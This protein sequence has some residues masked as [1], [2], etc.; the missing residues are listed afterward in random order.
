MEAYRQGDVLLVPIEGRQFTGLARRD[1]RVVRREKD[2]L[3]L[4]HGE[5]TGHSHHI[6]SRKATLRHHNAVNLATGKRAK[7]TCLH[8]HKEGALLEHQEHAPIALA[9]G[10][11]EVRRQTEY[12]PP[13]SEKKPTTRESFEQRRYVYD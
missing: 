10:K 2:G 5:A 13:A 12:A 9:P 3:V 1:G 7:F 11:Y 4:A 8:V 6:K